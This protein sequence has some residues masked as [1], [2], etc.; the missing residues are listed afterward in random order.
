MNYVKPP[1]QR[2]TIENFSPN[3][4]LNIRNVTK[5]MVGELAPG[6]VAAGLQFV[7]GIVSMP[8]FFY[9]TSVGLD[10]IVQ[11][12]IAIINGTQIQTEE[13]KTLDI[14]SLSNSYI[15]S[16]DVLP[17]VDGTDYIYVC[18]YY[19]PT[20]K[21]APAY[22]GLIYNYDNVIDD[23]INVTF[24]GVLEITVSSNVIVSI[25]SILDRH[26]AYS[27]RGIKLLESIRTNRYIDG[28]EI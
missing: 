15:F 25:D 16:D 6:G 2:F 18:L 10:I 13:I 21:D 8:T 24:L 5:I 11:P 28:G 4:T 7:N 14:T 9:V 23:D 17:P 19:N 3:T 22:V 1:I 27:T 26:P 20:S 12:G